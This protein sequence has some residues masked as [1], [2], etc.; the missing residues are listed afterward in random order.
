MRPPLRCPPPGTSEDIVKAFSYVKAGLITTGN[1]VW[2]AASSGRYLSLEGRVRGGVFQNWAQRFRY[3][4]DAV[5]AAD[6]RSRDRG[7]GQRRA[8]PAGLRIGPLLQR[9]H[10]VGGPAGLAGPLQ[11]TGGQGPGQTADHGQRRYPDP[12]RGAA[13]GRRGSGLPGAAL[14]RRPEHRRHPVHRRTRHGPGLGLRQRV[15]GTADPGR[16]AG[17]RAR[18][19]A[20]GRA[21]PR[22]DRRGRGG[23]HHHRSGG[24]GRA[25]V[26]CRAARRDEGPRLR[27]GA[28]GRD[29]GRER[30][31]QPVRVPVQRLLPGQ[32]LEPHRPRRS[33]P[34]ATCASS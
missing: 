23:R 17:R 5:R 16:R 18:V 3:H 11:R 13:A 30:A 34:A 15:R 10:R 20:G 22:R 9:R 12:R 29:A 1:I 6:H 33:R 25:A 8:Q 27:S 24:A 32:H 14:P 26:Q 28:P 2:Y 31:P 7:T 19:R 4:A 21:V